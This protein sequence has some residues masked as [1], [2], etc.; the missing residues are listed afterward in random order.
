MKEIKMSVVKVSNKSRTILSSLS[1]FL[2][3]FGAD[4]FYAGRITLGIIKIFG[5]FLTFGIWAI[6][7]FVLALIGKQKDANSAY[8]QNW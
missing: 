8:I 6:V 5:V 7:D 1:F 4:R 2:G 3:C